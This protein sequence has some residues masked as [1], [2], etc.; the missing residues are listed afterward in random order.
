MATSRAMRAARVCNARVGAGSRWIRKAVARITGLGVA[1]RPMSSSTVSSATGA[2]PARGIDVPRAQNALASADAVCFDVD[3]TVVTEEGIDVLAASLSPEV[4][5]KVAAYTAS[6]MGGTVPFQDA[7][8]ARLD[9]MRPSEQDIAR[10]MADH[11][12]QFSPGCREFVSALKN[13]G[14]DVYLVSGGFRQMIAPVAAALDVDPSTEVFANNLLFD[15]SG[16]Y[17]GFDTA[18]P[19]SRS[20]GKPSVVAALKESKGYRSVVM[21]GDGATDMEARPPA[22]AFIGYGGVAVREA[23]EQGA[24]WFVTDFQDLIDVLGATSK[25]ED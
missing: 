8:R 25:T 3:S 22:D 1:A 7:L 2:T 11:P 5:A 17:R 14:V 19:T 20:G 9:I 18:E 6:A 24:D 15:E 13:R 23:V 4:G 12:L 21:V 16:A 10:C